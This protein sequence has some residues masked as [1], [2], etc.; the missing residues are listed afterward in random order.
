MRIIVRIKR[1]KYFVHRM[2]EGP[3]D[4]TSTVL[5]ALNETQKIDTRPNTGEGVA[6]SYGWRKKEQVHSVTAT[7][8]FWEQQQH[9]WERQRHFRGRRRRN[10]INILIIITIIIIHRQGKKI[11]ILYFREFFFLF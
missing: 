6:V 2:Q 8:T 9:F 4:A 11:I 10:L 7:T 3:F 5:V 1:T